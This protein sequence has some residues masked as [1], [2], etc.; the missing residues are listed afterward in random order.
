MILQ[1]DLT[2][3]IT[4]EY[5]FTDQQC[6]ET[7]ERKTPGLPYSFQRIELPFSKENLVVLS[8]GPLTGTGRQVLCDS[9]LRYCRPKQDL[10]HHMTVRKISRIM[11]AIET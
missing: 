2:T 5:S 10:T 7:L 8:T 9:I 11:T 4:T 6:R 1:I 3:E